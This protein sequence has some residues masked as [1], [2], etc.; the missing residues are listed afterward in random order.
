MLCCHSLRHEEEEIERREYEVKRELKKLEGIEGLFP[1][2]VC[3]N[4]CTRVV[5]HTV[6]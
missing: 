2:A 1:W 4:V 6:H 3:T 5:V